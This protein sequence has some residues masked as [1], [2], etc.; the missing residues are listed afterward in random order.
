MITE[1]S[2][3]KLL[4]QPPRNQEEANKRLGLATDSLFDFKGIKQ[5]IPFERDLTIFLC[6]NRLTVQDDTSVLWDSFVGTMERAM[7]G[8][9]KDRHKLGDMLLQELCRHGICVLV[10][11]YFRTQNAT[12]HA[13]LADEEARVR[14]ETILSNAVHEYTSERAEEDRREARERI[15]MMPN[16]DITATEFANVFNGNDNRTT[17]RSTRMGSLRVLTQ[18]TPVNERPST[19]DTLEMIRTFDPNNPATREHLERMGSVFAVPR[20]MVEVNDDV[21]F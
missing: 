13:L 19:E 18:R 3:L 2:L 8:G 1:N 15:E 4:K 11:K 16:R 20:E 6:E 21:P 12:Y 17:E 9:I 10:D 5:I 7:K 14:R